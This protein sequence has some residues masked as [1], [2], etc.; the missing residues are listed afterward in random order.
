M[1]NPHGRLP[2]VSTYRLGSNGPEVERI[3]KRLASLGIYRGPVDGVFGGGTEAAVRAFQKSENLA[4]DGDVGPNTWKALFRNAIPAPALSAKPLDL[5]CLTLT[6]TFE[7]GQPPPECFA[8]LSGDFDGQGISMGVL[9]WNF[10]QDSLQPLLKE[11]IDKHPAVVRAVFQAQLDVLRAA[12]SGDK[13]ELMR[14]AAGIQD[15]LRHRVNEPWRGMFKALC[16]TEEFQAIQAKYAA[17]IFAAAKRLAAGY[18]LASPRATAL[19]FDIVVQNGSISGLVK[20]QIL[21][22]FAAIPAAAGDA[23]VQR[24][25]IIANRRAEAARPAWVE[26]VRS[27]KLCIARGTGTVHGIRYDLQQQFGIGLT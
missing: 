21:S 22:D 2:A 16:R 26:D 12:L 4:L 10:G 8:G 5:R 20:A 23:E 25:V 14:F 7:T 27:R 6:G 17:K 18:Q 24:M 1:R 9:Q 13:A 19:M 3:Q 15:P 11:V